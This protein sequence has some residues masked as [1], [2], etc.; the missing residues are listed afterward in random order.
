MSVEQIRKRLQ[1]Q[2]RILQLLQERGPMQ[3]SAL[4]TRLKMRKSSV[5]SIV[6]NL[7]ERG[8]LKEIVPG[9]LRSP[10]GLHGAGFHAIVGFLEP[11]ALLLARIFFDGRLENR[12]RIRLQGP[13]TPD[14]IL[15]QVARHLRSFVET[16][17]DSTLLGVGLAI[18]GLVEPESGIGINAVN[19]RN[20]RHV[21]VAA[22]LNRALGHPVHIANDG[23]C[24]LLGNAWFSD[25]CTRRQTVLYLTLQEGIACS[26]MVDGKLLDG[27]HHA[28]GEI[29]CLRSGN[30]GRPCRCGKRDCLQ[31][32][33]SAHAILAD[34]RR[35][36]PDHAFEDVGEIA[37]AAREDPAVLPAL[38]RILQPLS[39]KVSTLMALLDPE[40]LVVG[41]ADSGFTALLG[42]ALQEQLDVELLGLYAQSTDVRAGLPIEEA[43]LKGVAALVMDESFRSGAFDAGVA[44]AVAR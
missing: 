28:T 20:W 17:A 26:V 37:A 44:N 4:S 24:Q 42:H 6:S 16:P 36:C 5:T 29:G 43:T 12:T 40:V 11:Q 31:T 21:P 19:F 38:G 25:A 41:T 34:L 27:A 33:V 18:P 23:R 2:R 39:E 9:T 1:N 14:S 35:E 32:Y 8:V 10:V 3:R 30:Q 15:P 22:E 7:L 13:G